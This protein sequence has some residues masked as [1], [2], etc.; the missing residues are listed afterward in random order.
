[1]N[2]F[3]YIKRAYSELTGSSG[4]R[5]KASPKPAGLAV[6][7]L[8]SI[9][10]ILTLVVLAMFLTFSEEKPRPAASSNVDCTFLIP[11]PG[12]APPA[13]PGDGNRLDTCLTLE[14]VSSRSD[15]ILGLSGRDSLP[16][17]RGMLFDYGQPGSYCMWM[18]DMNFNIDIMWLDRTGEILEIR[19]N[20]APETYPDAYCGPENSV[21]VIEVNEGIVRSAG[22]RVGQ[23]LR[24]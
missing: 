7:A 11:R 17:D 4:G 18:K 3:D 13:V 8:L 14:K 5:K 6:P 12:S 9:G 21:Y 15:L 2:I 19:E 1:M 23:R 24:I 22:L 16:E 20:I 10:F